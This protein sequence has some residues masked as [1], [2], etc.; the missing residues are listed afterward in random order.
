MM[1]DHLDSLRGVIGERT[2][3]TAL[4]T[5]LTKQ[6]I[7]PSL[8]RFGAPSSAASAA[9]FSAHAHASGLMAAER[10][11]LV[12]PGWWRWVAGSASPRRGPTPPCGAA[13]VV[14]TRNRQA[15]AQ[16]R[17]AHA[18]S[19]RA[20]T[21]RGAPAGVPGSRTTARRPRQPLPA[22]ST[23][24]G[25]SSRRGGS[26]PTLRAV[27]GGEGE[28]RRG[29]GAARGALPAARSGQQ[30]L[31]RASRPRR[32]QPPEQVAVVVPGRRL[33]PHPQHHVAEHPLLL[34]LRGRL[35]GARGRARSAASE[36][37]VV[38]GRRSV[39]P[40]CGASHACAALAPE[41]RSEASARAPP[42]RGRGR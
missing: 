37:R 27:G 3:V 34:R 32:L 8:S 21:S 6:T 12:V 31:P 16:P 24:P 35:R 30:Q 14:G 7:A 1:R 15:P 4:R 13:G 20:K 26:G 23:S 18:P 25:R 38:V 41:A 39:A 36:S 11:G 33:V 5:A 42:R 40:A 19:A 28:G 10:K 22:G 2:A 17:H 9:P 29:V